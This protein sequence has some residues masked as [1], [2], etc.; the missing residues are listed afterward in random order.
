MDYDYGTLVDDKWFLAIFSKY[1]PILLLS[2][3]DERKYQIRVDF[4]S[5]WGIG[6]FLST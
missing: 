2:G 5:I 3:K 6:I 1:C 4:D